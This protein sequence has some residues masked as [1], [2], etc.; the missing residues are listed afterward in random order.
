M[1]MGLAAGYV[2]WLAC[3]SA[4][5][6]VVPVRYVVVAGLVVLAVMIAA[7]VA[8]AMHF[9]RRERKAISTAFWCAPIGPAVASVYSLIVLLT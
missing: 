4:L 5:T 7:A 3:M 2:A 6:F 8:L 9:C 1:L